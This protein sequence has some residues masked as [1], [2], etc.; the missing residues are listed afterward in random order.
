MPTRRRG[1]SASGQ[2][3]LVVR[4]ILTGA[5]ND[6]ETRFIVLTL[7]VTVVLSVTVVGVDGPNHITAHPRPSPVPQPAIVEEQDLQHTDYYIV[8][9]L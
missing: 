6:D 7:R 4:F 1:F 2:V 8:I 9:I 5:V 3:L